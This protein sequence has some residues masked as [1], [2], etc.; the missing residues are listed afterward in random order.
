MKDKFGI[1]SFWI[2]SYYGNVEVI[3]LFCKNTMIDL[4]STNENGSNA[5][6]IACKRGFLEVVK[7]LMRHQYPLNTPKGNGVTALG[8]AAHEGHLQ[9]VKVLAE[10]GADIN[11]TT[12]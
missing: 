5:L 9:I 3:R 12:T 6:H 8:I 1:N 7:E 11:K 2:A 10:S 4:H